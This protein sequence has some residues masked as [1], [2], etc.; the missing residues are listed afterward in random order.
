MRRNFAVRQSSQESDTF[1]D[2]TD[3]LGLPLLTAGTPWLASVGTGRTLAIA[4]PGADRA[5]PG[6]VAK[7]RVPSVCVSLAQGVCE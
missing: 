4:A 1:L 6:V 7:V 2:G 3:P 5:A